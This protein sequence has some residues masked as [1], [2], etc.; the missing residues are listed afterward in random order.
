MG[1]INIGTGGSEI[2]ESKI[3]VETGGEAPE[4]GR[5]STPTI[6]RF[7]LSSEAGQAT[8]Q[9]FIDKYLVPIYDRSGI[10]P[11]IVLVTIF[12]TFVLLAFYMGVGV[13]ILEFLK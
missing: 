11:V 8:T 9:N 1:D 7:N 4:S 12:L 10:V 6:S 2:S 5:E 3:S 13:Y